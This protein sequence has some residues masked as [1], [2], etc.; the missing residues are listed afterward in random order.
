MET[1]KK[2]GVTEGKVGKA[3]WAQKYIEPEKGA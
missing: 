3:K 2:L 1:A